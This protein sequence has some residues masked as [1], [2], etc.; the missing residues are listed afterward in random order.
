MRVKDIFARAGGGAGGAIVALAVPHLGCL[1]ALVTTFVGAGAGAQLAVGASYA[2]GMA[3]AA[4]GVA[5]AYYG[6]RPSRE[7]CCQLWGET[8]KVRIKKALAVSAFAFAAVA[9]F[10]TLNDKGLPLDARAQVL[11][12]A[13]DSGQSV[14]Q[15]DEMLNSICSSAKRTGFL[16]FTP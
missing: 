5:A 9:G 8:P 4:G 6:F 13:R 2:A 16:W 14:W 12:Q 11:E 7:A 1:G 3:I 15:M 10:N